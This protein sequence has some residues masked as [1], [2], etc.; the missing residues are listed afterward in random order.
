MPSINFKVIQ[1]VCLFVLGSVPKSNVFSQLPGCAQ[2]DLGP[3]TTI[4]CN[5]SCVTLQATVVEVGL[6]DTYNV[7][8]IP[9]V[10]PY[11]FSQG[12]PIIVDIDD[13]WSETIPL[14]FNF[15]F[16][17]NTYSEV[18]V[19]SNGVM[20]FDV[21][22]ASPASF[23]EE[24]ASYC[25]WEF[26]QTIPNAAGFPYT[27][28]INGVYHDVDPSIG[29]EIKYDIS[30]VYPCRTFVVNFLDAPQ[31]SCNTL[32][33]T[34]QIVLYETTNI[35]EIYVLD[36]PTCTGWN[37]G[38]ALIGIQ[39]ETGT[40]G[41]APPNRNTGPWS[42]TN[43]A[44]RFSPN[45]VGTYSIEWYDDLG[46]VIG[47]S[48]TLEVCPIESTTYSAKVTYDICDGTQ[49]EETDVINI[50]LANAQST[51]LNTVSACYNY[52]W[53]GVTYTSSGSYDFIALNSLGCDSTATLDL[54]ITQPSTS[55]SSA[56]SC[57][58]YLWN[59]VTYTASGSYDFIALNSV[60]CD[61]TATL[62]L[63]ITVDPNDAYIDMQ[64]CNEFVWNG[65]TYTESGEY[66]YT[67]VN[68]YGCESTTYLSLEVFYDNVFIPNAFTPDNDGV[69]DSFF[70]EGVQLDWFRLVV[71]NR[72]G[73][74]LFYTEDQNQVWDGTYNGGYH[75]CQDGVYAWRVSY[76]C[77]NEYYEKLGQ[78]TLIR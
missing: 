28:S 4:S 5:S 14:P 66:E 64:V 71:Y 62:D 21:S 10:P 46:I 45:G 35:I 7:S 74:Q 54:T 50:V 42:A 6:T 9:Y 37:D 32:L 78:V 11:P 41:Y 67:S 33:S 25:E 68:M 19:G 31:Y 1:V 8:S 49:V 20:T 12:T 29:G 59:G 39:N 18:V 2:I 58:E 23:T 36:K 44:W 63:L 55:L 34:H 40:L 13:I 48:D 65:E 3:D 53:N 15:C 61:S 16:F 24:N 60:G 70:V 27:N 77:L 57:V 76:R 38:N 26:T 47:S 69:N 56:V 72:W 17:G 30:G 73:E 52:I 75:L 51:S 43:E 22:L